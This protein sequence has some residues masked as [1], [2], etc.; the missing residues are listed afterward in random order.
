[1]KQIGIANR[2]NPTRFAYT[3]SMSRNLVSTPN[4]RLLEELITTVD[5]LQR[6]DLSAAWKKATAARLTYLSPGSPLTFN[7][8]RPQTVCVDCTHDGL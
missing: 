7:S 3:M 6:S 4:E 8:I 5:F 2:S 1:M